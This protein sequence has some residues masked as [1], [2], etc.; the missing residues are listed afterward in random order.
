MVMKR[1]QRT[2][3]AAGLLVV[4]VTGLYIP[5]EITHPSQIAIGV[6]IRP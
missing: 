4:V 2:I 1:G 3:L 5:W 6:S